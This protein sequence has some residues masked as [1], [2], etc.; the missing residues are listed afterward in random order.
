MEPDAGLCNTMP[1]PLR[2]S[3]A[4]SFSRA[5]TKLNSLFPAKNR[6]CAPYAWRAEPPRWT[7]RVARSHFIKRLPTE[8]LAWIFV[9]GAEDDD[10]LPVTVSHVCSRWRAIALHTPSLWRRIPLGP[11]E[12]MWRERI[13]RA[14]ACP[15]DVRLLS[16]RPVRAGGIVVRQALDVHTV[17]LCMHLVSPS[18]HRW[19]SL[20]ITLPEYQPF[21][22][23]A[24]LSPCCS[25]KRRAKALLL[26]ELTL[27][28]R[29]NDD[30]KEF[31]LF[32][33]HTPRLRRLTVDGLRLTWLPSLFQN[34]TFLDFTH[35]GFSAGDEAV[36]E[37]LSMLTV[38]A[39]LRELRILFPR[40]SLARPPG[41]FYAFMRRVTLPWLVRLH[42][43]VETG[44]IPSE[45]A[46]LVTHLSTPALTSLYLIDLGR[47]RH[48]FPSLTLFMRTYPALHALET[49]Y[50]EH[51]WHGSFV[52]RRRGRRE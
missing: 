13:Y 39:G 21:L 24:A 28:Y 35:H 19:R 32:S 48:A 9:L 2:R 25:R 31:C 23:N 7:L 52:S 41:A 44:D 18:I 34:L 14:K 29:L 27:V 22:A 50:L 6:T 11:Q 36:S 33:G 26:E 49:V 17:Q 47:R 16:W 42:L 37:L 5:V 38:C 51:G 10:M 30:T 40:K 46:R 4:S 3:L 15:L 20:E 1:S 8:I 43:R 45:L 12:R